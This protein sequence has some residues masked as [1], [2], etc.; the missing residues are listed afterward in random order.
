MCVNA[1]MTV[2]TRVQG[3]VSVS[4][5]IEAEQAQ[6]AFDVLLRSPCRALRSRTCAK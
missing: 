5:L 1:T 4:N 3:P 2:S 6:A